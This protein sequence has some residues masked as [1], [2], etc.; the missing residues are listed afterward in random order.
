[1]NAIHEH[2]IVRT[3]E[4]MCENDHPRVYYKINK[5]GFAICGYCNVKFIYYG[6]KN[7]NA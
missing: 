6:E 7:E 2:K 4:V 3:K 1:M 5:D